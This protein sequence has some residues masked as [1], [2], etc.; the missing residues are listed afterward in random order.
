M[1]FNLMTNTVVEIHPFSHDLFNEC[2]H[3]VHCTCYQ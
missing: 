3:K 1:L 2:V